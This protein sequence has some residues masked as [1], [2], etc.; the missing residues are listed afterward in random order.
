MHLIWEAIYYI[1]VD[2]L[3]FFPENVSL[4]G[5]HFVFNVSNILSTN[6]KKPNDKNKQKISQTYSTKD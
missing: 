4:I 3:G 6:I 1:D 5:E 2:N